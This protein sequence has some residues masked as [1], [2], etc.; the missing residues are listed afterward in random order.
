MDLR[1]EGP[2][3]GGDGSG[4]P[5]IVAAAVA[6]ASG[7]Y[8]AVLLVLQPGYQPG[9]DSHY[10]FEIAGE[11]ARG[12]LVPDVARG[13]P[14]TVLRDMP[15]DH[16]WGYHCLLAPFALMAD[17]E[18]GMKLATAV[19]FGAV[20][21]SAYLFL[22]ARGVAYAWAWALLPACF[23]TQDWR[24][25]QLRGG[26]LV[27]PLVFAMAQVAFFE[28]RPSRRR[29]WLVG[30]A[31]LALLSYHGGVVL[32][33]LH[34]GGVAAL[35][36]LRPSELA[37]G[38][39]FEPLLTALG[40]ALG[41]TLN[42]YFDARASTW[43]FFAFHVGQMGRDAAHLY[44]DQDLAEFHG[45]PARLLLAHPEWLLLLSAV[46]VAVALVARDA[47]ARGTR[48]PVR[49]D[50]IV[51][52]GMALAGVVLTS[53]AMRTREYSVPLGFSLL[54]VLAP[55]SPHASAARTSAARRRPTRTSARVSGVLV[56]ALLAAF[57]LHAAQTLPLIALHLPT[58][59]YAG[60]RAVLE[61]N[62][63][64][65]ILN[66]AEADYGMLRWEYDRVVGVQGLSR[67]FIYPYKGLFHDV[68]E[69]HD[70]ADTSPET[71][72]ILRRF[73]ERG[74]RLVAVHRTHAMARF[75][76]AHPEA[77]RLKFRSPI[78]GAAI[79]ELIETP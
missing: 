49:R 76:E 56:G 48:R 62:G 11:I 28:E 41:L 46:L 26:Q 44:D 42:P 58:R 13:L 59:Q 63:E 57:G 36:L 19:L 32:L 60:A 66:I 8:A 35:W 71:M 20:F 29:A 69:L 75:A 67:Y 14:F 43:R 27:V 15:V 64:R 74:V 78:N 53:Q 16:Y 45:F 17:R 47:L 2:S 22:R 72:A 12:H 40:L 21:A 39:I 54:A 24:Y 25:L 30:I 7:A 70:H 4:R 33:P 77:L 18:L 55:R 3:G 9:A 23:S 1:Q 51:L 61:A 34:V 5:G 50:A 6:L 52:A 10:H 73:R 37:R 31:Y 68:W 79:Y 65:P 38:Q